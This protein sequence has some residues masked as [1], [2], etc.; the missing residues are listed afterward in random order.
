MASGLRFPQV[1]VAMP[2]L[3]ATVLQDDHDG[4][5][6]LRDVLGPPGESPTLSER[7]EPRIRT[8]ETFVTSGMDRRLEIGMAEALA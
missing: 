5:G 3:D 8:S 2:F 1:D 4:L 7:F 6:F